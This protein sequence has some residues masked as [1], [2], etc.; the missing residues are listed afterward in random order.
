[1][2]KFKSEYNPYHWKVDFASDIMILQVLAMLLVNALVIVGFQLW[3]VYDLDRPE[4]ALEAFGSYAVLDSETDGKLS[5][6]LL[7]SP[8]GEKV[9]LTVE[10]HILFKQYRPM[11]TKAIPEDGTLRFTGD[12]VQVHM[13]IEKDSIRQYA[14]SNFGIALTQKLPALPKVYVLYGTLMIA[15]EIAAYFLFRKL[16]GK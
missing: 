13:T 5:S 9:V 10:E 11:K 2:S 14:V 3:F 4:D 7:A 1:M 6:W 8:D 15:L 12:A 16:H